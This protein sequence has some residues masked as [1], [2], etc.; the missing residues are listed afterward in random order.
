MATKKT[1]KKEVAETTA[2]AEIK[3]LTP[4]VTEKSGMLSG[5]RQYTFIVPMTANKPMI[6]AA[7]KAEY[8][9]DPTHITISLLPSKPVMRAGI[10]GTKAGMKKAVVT[11]KKGDKIEFI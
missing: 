7:F 10:P 8:K 2:K 4:R 9:K 1:T 6:R 3:L 5:I 11:L